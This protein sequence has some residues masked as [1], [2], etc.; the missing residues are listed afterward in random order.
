MV[1]G[2]ERGAEGALRTAGAEWTVAGGELCVCGLRAWDQPLLCAERVEGGGVVVTLGAAG[3]AG[4][5]DAVEV[6]VRVSRFCCDQPWLPG[7]RFTVGAVVVTTGAAG[8][9]VGA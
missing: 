4:T 3:V 6:R 2:C 8:S 9:G 5:A 7:E 1:A